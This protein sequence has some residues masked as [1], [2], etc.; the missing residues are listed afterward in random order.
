MTMNQNKIRVIQNSLDPFLFPPLVNIVALYARDLP[1][2]AIK[3]DGTRLFNLSV[4]VQWKTFKLMQSPMH[5]LFNLV[6]EYL[7]EWCLHTED[8]FLDSQLRA[9]HKNARCNLHDLEAEKEVIARF[10]Y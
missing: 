6:T 4:S 9:F 10:L 7:D 5:S 8:R 1:I 2:R 3:I